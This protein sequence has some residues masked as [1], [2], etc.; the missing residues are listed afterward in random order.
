MSDASSESLITRI[1]QSFLLQE[2]QDDRLDSSGDALSRSL[3][4]E[5]VGGAFNEIFPRRYTERDCE[6]QEDSC[7]F[8][9]GNVFDIRE[10]WCWFGLAKVP[11]PQDRLCFGRWWRDFGNCRRRSYWQQQCLAEGVGNSFDLMGRIA[12]PVRGPDANEPAPPT[13]L[14]QHFLANAV[15]VASRRRAVVRRAVTLNAQH[16]RTF[17]GLRKLAAR[18]CVNQPERASV[19]WH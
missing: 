19:E 7:D 8:A 15:T 13:K 17:R 6:A 1:S 14:L 10:T 9:I 2:A 16:L 5:F 4:P 18:Q 12:N 11:D 3:K